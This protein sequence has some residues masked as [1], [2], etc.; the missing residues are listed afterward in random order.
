[1]GKYK[2]IFRSTKIQLLN[3][4][5][6]TRIVDNSM[7][8]SKKIHQNPITTGQDFSLRTPAVTAQVFSYAPFRAMDEKQLTLL[9]GLMVLGFVQVFLIDPSCLDQ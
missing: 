7:S 3:I 2:F 5:T 6:V 1:M 4:N 8:K 9:Y